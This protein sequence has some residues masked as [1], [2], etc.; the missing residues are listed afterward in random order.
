MAVQAPNNMTEWQ[1]ALKPPESPAFYY[2]L[3]DFGR[4]WY[5]TFNKAWNLA[6]TKPAGLGNTPNARAMNGPH[7]VTSLRC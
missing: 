3:Q 6:L 5:G 4:A 7:R 1:S 2:L